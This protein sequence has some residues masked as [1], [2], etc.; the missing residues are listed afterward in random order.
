MILILLILVSSCQGIELVPTVGGAYH[1]DTDTTSA[2]VAVSFV[3]S[4]SGDEVPR[5]SN[6][7]G[8]PVGSNLRPSR[9]AYTTDQERP[10]TPFDKEG[11]SN[12][13]QPVTIETPWGTFKIAGLSIAAIAAACIVA[14]RSGL[15]GKNT[16]TPT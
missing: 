5:D 3:S 14:Q 1:E 9:S 4:S 8:G 12:D 2:M 15:F 16:S 7:W 11:N 6:F 13:D 10:R